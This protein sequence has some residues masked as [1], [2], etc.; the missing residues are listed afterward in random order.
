MKQSLLGLLVSLLI[1][2]GMT[3]ARAQQGF[4]IRFTNRDLQYGINAPFYDVDGTTRLSGENF[5][6][7]LYYAPGASPEQM[8]Q[9]GAS[10]GFLTGA[11][12]GYF[13][14]TAGRTIATPSPDQAIYVQ[15]RFWETM[16][17]ASSFEAVH[18]AH[19]KVGFSDVLRLTQEPFGQSIPLRGLKSTALIAVC[20]VALG[21]TRSVTDVMG[22]PNGLQTGT[23]CAQPVGRTRWFNLIFANPGEAVVSTEGSSIDTVLSVFT[24]C[25]L[26]SNACA[27]V[28]CSDDAKVRFQAQSGVTYAVAVGGN[29]GATG[30]LQLT[31]SMPVALAAQRMPDRKV[32]ISWPAE[33]TEFTVE[34]TTNTALAGSWASAGETPSTNGG[35][36]RLQVAPDSP[37]R[38]YRLRRNTP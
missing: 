33:A 15:V 20:P 38:F 18:A 25:L 12:A 16:T 3:A 13:G 23:L 11:S 21:E 37:Q 6:V 29:N 10:I 7:A 5:R 36:Y 34:T 9:S 8:V 14:N 22:A 27:P 32:E 28:A 19:G 30:A 26:S 1:I 4:V 24:S 2:T 31:F 17:G 35:R